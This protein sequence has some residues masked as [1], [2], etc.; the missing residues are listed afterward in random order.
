MALGPLGLSCFARDKVN[1]TPAFD[2]AS[3]LSLQLKRTRDKLD[4]KN[5]F[6]DQL[7]GELRKLGLELEASHATVVEAK[8]QAATSATAKAECEEQLQSR[9][10]QIK[11]LQNRNAELEAGHAKLGQGLGKDNPNDDTVND[12]I[13]STSGRVIAAENAAEN[14]LKEAESLRHQLA[15]EREKHEETARQLK[16]MRKNENEEVDELKMDLAHLSVGLEQR[17][18]DILSIQFDM[19]ALQNTLKDQTR[20]VSA[21]A[22]AFQLASEELADKDDML[23]EALQKQ[24]ELMGQM[25]SVSAQ[26]QEKICR[27]SREL[28]LSKAAYQTLEEQSENN[29]AELKNDRDALRAQ[30]RRASSE[31]VSGNGGDAAGGYIPDVRQNLGVDEK[32]ISLEERLSRATDRG[33]ELAR[34]LDRSRLLERQATERAQEYRTSLALFR[35]FGTDGFMAAAPRQT[36]TPPIS[37][38]RSDLGNFHGLDFQGNVARFAS[39]ELLRPHALNSG[40]DNGWQTLSEVSSDCPLQAHGE[41]DLPSVLIAVELDCGTA[42]IAT[43]RVAPWQTRGDFE[44]VVCDFL[45]QH[46]LKS[47]FRHA[48]IKYLEVVEEEATTFPANLKADLAGL[49]SMYG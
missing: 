16:T 38:V 35:E 2:E 14:A 29:V 27:L 48:L 28:N 32:M 21:N 49:Y 39:G 31:V 36:E 41:V 37:P 1:E 8:E 25:N 26:L 13:C 46:R 23:G 33:S 45:V 20:L 5:K 6:C 22:E 40:A 18:E 43:L 15:L 3:W 9:K 30:L 19:A 44:R 7:A 17:E 24:D 34:A 42:G 4:R 47:V 12:E 10:S 11:N